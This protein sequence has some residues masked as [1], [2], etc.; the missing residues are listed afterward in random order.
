M[1]YQSFQDSIGIVYVEG[2]IDDV[3]SII[4]QLEDFADNPLVKGI[5][6]RVESPG[7]AVASSQEV[8]SEILKIR[9]EKPIY[10]SAGNYAASGGYYILSATEKIFANPGSVTGSIGVILQIPNVE[11]L[12][13]K[14]GIG[15]ETLKSG[16]FKD[17]GSLFRTPSI[18]DRNLLSE[19]IL[20]IHQQFIDDILKQRPQL[21]K[22]QLLAVADG[23]ILTGRQAYQVGIVD[24]LGS[25][26]DALEAL[27][28]ALN[29]EQYWVLSKSEQTDVGFF[30]M[31]Q[32]THEQ[33]KQTFQ[34]LQ[35]VS[36]KLMAY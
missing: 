4:E 27:A 34:Q 19:N 13:E 25:Q 20:D 12:I 15:M 29:L 3:T 31:M 16:T 18:D 26:N 1:K 36:I 32:M 21:D 17:T 5:L 35:T 24:E 23:R 2:E 9:E 11:G 33:M 7:G 6:V 8:Y 28:D 22:S 30:E 14:I 10:G